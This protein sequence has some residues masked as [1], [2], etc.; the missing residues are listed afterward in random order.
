MTNPR[1]DS[2]RAYYDGEIPWLMIEDLN[3][4]IVSTSRKTI[5]KA[6]LE[7]SSAKL[8]PP[9]TLVIAMYGSIGKLGITSIECAT[10][11]AIAF[12]KCDREKVDVRYLY[13]Y[14]LSIRDWLL[15]QGRGGTQQNITQEFLKN[16]P[17]KLP[18]LLEQKR[19]ATILNKANRLRRLRRYALELSD[20]FLQSVFLGMF[21]DPATNPKGWLV[22]E[23]QEL[24]SVIVD[25]PHA[26]PNYENQTTEYAV[27]RSSDIQDGYLD[28]STTLYV[29]KVEYTRRIER[30]IPIADDV[31][32]CREGARYGNAARIP[33]G[34]KVCLGQRMMLLRASGSV[35]TPEYLWALC[36]SKSTLTQAEKWA[37]GSASP[38][39][40]VQDIK[41]FHAIIPPLSLQER[42][43]LIVRKQDLLRK[44]MFEAVRLSDHAFESLINLSFEKVS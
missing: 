39:V 31:I 13:F 27:I 5:T 38:H 12:C 35:A 37:G 21:G 18:E 43:T 11:Q 36:Q 14:L 40:N 19:I 42:F 3:D 17:I 30:T 4:G 22:G 6:G 8:V 10:N 9:G 7:N 2:N 33:P 44:E 25:C 41:E 20:T 16:A 29:N 24:C 23:L 26:T 15:S 34:R 32:Y 28:W 1:N